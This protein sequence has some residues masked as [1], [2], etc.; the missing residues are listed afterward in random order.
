MA[1]S[2]LEARKKNGPPHPE[3]VYFSPG[4]RKEKKKKTQCR[5]G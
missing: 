5:G 3:L 4:W 2:S 1:F